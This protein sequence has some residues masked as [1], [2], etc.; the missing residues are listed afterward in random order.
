MQK[1]VWSVFG[2]VIVL[3]VFSIGFYGNKILS[4]DLITGNVVKDVGS[5]NNSSDF[6]LCDGVDFRS[7]LRN[8]A[9]NAPNV[10]R[11]IILQDFTSDVVTF[12]INGVL[13]NIDVNSVENING[14]NIFVR[15][16][17][18]EGVVFRVC[19]PN[20]FR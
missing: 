3:L 1:V 19:S 16:V 15:S 8:S 4:G 11:T 10:G 14:I 6:E 2:I 20:S 18:E 5:E 7:N 9:L 17:G 13:G 12:G